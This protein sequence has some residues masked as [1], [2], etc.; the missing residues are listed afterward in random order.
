MPGKVCVSLHSLHASFWEVTCGEW[1]VFITPENVKLKRKL[2][3]M[4]QRKRR[5]QLLWFSVVALAVS[6]FAVVV[7]R[8]IQK[9]L[10][11]L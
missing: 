2:R 4:A 5:N 8:V 3:E 6:I 10:V 1:A 11:L 7:W 9:A